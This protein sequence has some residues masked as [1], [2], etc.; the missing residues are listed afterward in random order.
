[1]VLEV[2]LGKVALSLLLQPKLLLVL[3]ELFR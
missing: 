3:E 2:R 1:V